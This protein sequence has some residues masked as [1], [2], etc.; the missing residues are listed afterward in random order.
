MLNNWKR[1][2]RRGGGGKGGSRKTRLIN[3]IISS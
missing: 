3:F 2:R 1:R